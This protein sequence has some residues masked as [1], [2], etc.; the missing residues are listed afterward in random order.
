MKKTLVLGASTNPERYSNKAVLLL[1]ENNIDLVAFGIKEGKIGE[2][3]IT[4]AFPKDSL[5]HTV[6]IYIRPE[7]QKDYIEK[8]LALMPKRI[9]F[10]PGTENPEFKIQAEEKGIL[11]E[12]ACTLVLLRT[13]QY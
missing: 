11:A 8:V 5:F 9:L 4:L 6:S 7:V 13:G 10:N 2:V 3:P 12:N 1:Q